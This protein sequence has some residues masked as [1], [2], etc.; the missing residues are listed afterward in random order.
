MAG[1]AVWAVLTFV[2]ILRRMTGV[3]ISGCVG[4]DAIDMACLAVHILVRADKFETR[5]V[6]IELSRLPGF[7]R[8]ALFA[9]GAELTQM[10]IDLFMAGVTIL[11]RAFEHA[12][13]MTLIA[14]HA[15]MSAIQFEISQIMVKGRSSPAFGSVTRSAVGAEAPFVSIILCMTRDAILAG[16]L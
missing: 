10:R 12:I 11:G 6:M 15:H 5:C 8:M 1:S 13:D 3:A 16:H 9:D 2:C 7:G 4:E 14:S